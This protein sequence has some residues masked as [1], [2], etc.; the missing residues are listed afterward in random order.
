MARDE[1]EESYSVMASYDRENY[2]KY[3]FN[4]DLVPPRFVVQGLPFDIEEL[5]CLYGLTLNPCDDSLFSPLNYSRSRPLRLQ[6]YPDSVIYFEKHDYNVS[7]FGFDTPIRKLYPEAP[8]PDL[9]KPIPPEQLTEDGY[10]KYYEYEVIINDLVSTVPYFVSVTAFDFGSPETGLEPL[11]TS[12]Q[13]NATQVYAA[14]SAAEA[15]GVMPDA[16][17]YPNPFRIDANYRADGFE[18]RGRD[19]VPEYRTYLINFANVPPQC[20]IRVFTLDGDLVK[21]FRHDEPIDSP[22]ARHATWDMVTRNR[23]LIVSGLYYWSIEADDGRTQIGKLV[24]L[25]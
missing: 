14:G 23:Q 2:D 19:D 18:G 21:E 4:A 8:L 20:W 11:E 24:V 13:L 6:D 16:Y 12:K 9:S 22:T 5:R 10:L 7:H 25:F 15:T 3:V 17:V 1:R